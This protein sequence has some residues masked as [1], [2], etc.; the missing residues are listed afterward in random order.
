ML[1]S[2]RFAIRNYFKGGRHPLGYI[3]V[4]S[5]INSYKI[6]PKNFD[7]LEEDKTLHYIVNK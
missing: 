1:P 2:L 7:D 3:G 5:D 4:G 6:N